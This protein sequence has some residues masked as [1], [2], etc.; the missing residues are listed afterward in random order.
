MGCFEVVPIDIIYLF[1]PAL[2]SS[3]VCFCLGF[4]RCGIGLDDL[5]G[6]DLWAE[7]SVTPFYQ[8]L[9][10]LLEELVIFADV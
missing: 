7:M 1:F 8:T 9:L 3:L 2:E 4:E 10:F 5:E 6:R